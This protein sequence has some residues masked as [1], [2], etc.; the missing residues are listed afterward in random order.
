M[1]EKEY[2]EKCV[3]LALKIANLINGENPNADVALSALNMAL[4]AAIFQA[5]EMSDLDRERTLSNCISHVKRIVEGLTRQ[6]K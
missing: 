5:S 2:Q 1:N 6:S 3:N 4:G